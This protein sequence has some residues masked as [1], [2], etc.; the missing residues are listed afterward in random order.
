MIPLSNPVGS[1]KTPISRARATT[2]Q[3]NPMIGLMFFAIR[4][5][6]VI[7]SITVIE[8]TI[9]VNGVKKLIVPPFCLVKKNKKNIHFF[10]NEIST[11]LDDFQI[12][13]ITKFVNNNFFIMCL[14]KPE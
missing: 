8:I 14:N 1:I 9:I 3:K 5:T 2:K 13:F 11:F 4:I 10:K 6:P 12:Y 7:T